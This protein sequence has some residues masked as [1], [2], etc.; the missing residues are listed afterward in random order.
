MRCKLQLHSIGTT[1]VPN[2]QMRDQK[3]VIDGETRSYNGSFGGVWE[4]SPEAQAAS[5]NAIFGSMTPMA[6]FN[7]MIRNEA[8]A[9]ALNPGKKYYVTFTEAPD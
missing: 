4:G 1:R 2:H 8:V 5:E 3:V 9:A 7:A 6:E